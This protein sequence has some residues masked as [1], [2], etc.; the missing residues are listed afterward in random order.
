VGRVA[1]RSPTRSTLE[2]AGDQR[3]DDSGEFSWWADVRHLPA[4]FPFESVKLSSIWPGKLQK[5]SANSRQGPPFSIQ[6]VDARGNFIPLLVPEFRI[7]RW[8]REGAK[9]VEIHSRPHYRKQQKARFRA[10]ARPALQC[11]VRAKP[12]YINGLDAFR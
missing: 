11:A 2:S 5:P 1:A 3:S 7:D 4:S 12:A 9:S 10:C 8:R 6:I